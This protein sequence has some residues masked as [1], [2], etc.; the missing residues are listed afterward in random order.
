MRGCKTVPPAF[1]E[2]EE[3]HFVA[4]HLVNGFPNQDLPEGFDQPMVGREKVP[5]R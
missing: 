2:V 1:L 5:G 3:D 4:C